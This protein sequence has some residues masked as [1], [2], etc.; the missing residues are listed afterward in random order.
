MISSRLH[1]ELQKE[2]NDYLV[3]LINR[4]KNS[5]FKL[6]DYNDL[7]FLCANL[8]GVDCTACYTDSLETI[9]NNIL[10][11]IKE[12]SA[13]YEFLKQPKMFGGLG[14]FALSI[15]ILSKKTNGLKKLLYSTNN[16][17]LELAYSY[18]YLY[19]NAEL[20]FD[21]YDIISGISGILYYLLEDSVLLSDDTNVAKIVVLAEYLIRLSNNHNSEGKE[22]INFH[23]KKEQYTD[24]DMQSMNNGHINFGMAHG[25]VG[26]LIALAKAESINLPVDGLHAAIEKLFSVYQKF[27]IKEKGVLKLPRKLSLEDYVVGNSTML[28]VNSGW[29]YG[30]AGI[31][32]G[33]MKAG[34]YIKKYDYYSY[35]EKEL[36][37]VINQPEK[38]YNFY[39]PIVCHGY[40]SIVSIQISALR[41]SNNKV[42]IKTLNRNMELLYN[43]HCVEKETNS[44]Y[45]KSPSLLFGSGGVIL[46]MIGSFNFNMDYDRILLIH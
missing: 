5:K 18:I 26:P 15:S 45:F 16:L 33:L 35:F 30:N 38:I 43:M 46:T 8:Y 9:I 28:S 11:G 6:M 19:E 23:I 2:I 3:Q 10:K 44:W 27:S 29:C 42:F 20:F 14:Q 22:V 39:S 1:L 25:M 21:F 7:F 4:Y 41:E 32:R 36:L 37:N 34:K 17:L 31:I 40:G 13:Q 24:I 12:N